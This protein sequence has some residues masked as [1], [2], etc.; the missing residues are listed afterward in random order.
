MRDGLLGRTGGWAFM[1][2]DIATARGYA[3][4]NG[5]GI[6]FRVLAQ[7]A[8]QNGVFFEDR[9]AY[10]VARQIHPGFIDFRWSLTS[11]VDLARQ[12]AA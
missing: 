3:R 9:G 1:A 2:P 5:G 12:H 7:R 4:G 6:V 11:I 10:Y 8:Y